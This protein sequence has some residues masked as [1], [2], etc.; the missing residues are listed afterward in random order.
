MNRKAD[1]NDAKIIRDIVHDIIDVLR[2]HEEENGAD[3]NHMGN[4]IMLM[5]P[6]LTLMVHNDDLEMAQE[7][8]Q[9]MLDHIDEKSNSVESLRDMRNAF[10][11]KGKDSVIF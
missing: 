11:E 7:K 8:L 4:A 2:H 10:Y 3:P 1:F 6:L 9:T 5:V